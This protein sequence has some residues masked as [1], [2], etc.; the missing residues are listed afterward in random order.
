[1]NSFIPYKTQS[2]SFLEFLYFVQ[3]PTVFFYI[4]RLYTNIHARSP[5]EATGRQGRQVF[6]NHSLEK[7]YNKPHHTQ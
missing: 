7:P 6:E 2:F 1:M 4:L 3:N 5:S